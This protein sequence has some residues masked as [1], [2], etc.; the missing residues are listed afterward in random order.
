MKNDFL[1]ETFGD[2]KILL[3]GLGKLFFQE[4]FPISVAITELKKMDI[5]V[6]ILHVADECL[7]HGWSPKTTISKIAEDF[8][9]GTEPVNIEQLKSFCNA[10]YEDQ[11]EMIFQDLFKAPSSDMRDGK[12][13]A[14]KEWLKSYINPN[15]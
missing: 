5:E 15:K 4:G 1:I 8:T 13:N 10:K 11:R 7:K 6:S 12:G 2:R 3:K 14:Q 9:Y